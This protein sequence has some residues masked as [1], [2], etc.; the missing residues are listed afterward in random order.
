MFDELMTNVWLVSCSEQTIEGQNERY[1]DIATNSAKVSK[2]KGDC[3]Q[4]CRL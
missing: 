2:I 3:E 4:M 1:D